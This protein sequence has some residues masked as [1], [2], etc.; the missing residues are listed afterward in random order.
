MLFVAAEYIHSPKGS[1]TRNMETMNVK[2]G[3]NY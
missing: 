3:D 2:T 1:E